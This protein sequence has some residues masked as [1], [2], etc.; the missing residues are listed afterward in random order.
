M[1]FLEVQ[2]CG[3]YWDTPSKVKGKLFHLAHPATTTQ[4]QH[5]VGPLDFGGNIVL[6]WVHYSSPFTGWVKN[7]PVLSGPRI[8]KDSKT[9]RGYC[10]HCSATWTTR[11]SGSNATKVSVAD[12]GTV[13]SLCYR[14]ITVQV[15]RILEQSLPPCIQ[16]LFLWETALGLLLS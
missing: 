11:S 2:W 14:W 10:A 3:A 16:L 7:L 5:L 4:K 6:M 15:L 8:R 9:S 13:W 12:R 1:K